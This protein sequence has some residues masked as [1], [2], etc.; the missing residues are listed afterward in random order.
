MGPIPNFFYIVI[1]LQIVNNN[2]KVK[3]NFFWDFILYLKKIK[4]VKI[5][6]AIPMIEFLQIFSIGL[7]FSINITYL[8]LIINK[9]I[10]AS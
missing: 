10:D 5:M 6:G 8:S 3:K 4:I 7:T 2:R 1:L 9:R